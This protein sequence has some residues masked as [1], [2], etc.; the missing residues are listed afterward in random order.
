MRLLTQ[1]A[2][3]RSKQ[4]FSHAQV[5]LPSPKVRSTRSLISV[6]RLQFS[7]AKLLIAIAVV[8]VLLFL[9]TKVGSFVEIVLFSFV[10]CVVPTPLVICAIY[11][12]GDVRSVR[13]RGAEPLDRIHRLTL[14]GR[15]RNVFPTGLAD[16]HGWNL[17]RGGRDYTPMDLA[18][19]K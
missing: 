19:Q 2:Q 8:A 1:L 13:H 16:G 6:P 3:T 5:R 17:W 4:A 10:A 9:A 18:G 7:L 14:P 12:R 11:G 15:E